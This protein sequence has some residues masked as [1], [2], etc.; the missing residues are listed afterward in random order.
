V[1]LKAIFVAWNNFELP[2]FVKYS[3]MY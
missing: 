3:I 1:T 2:Y